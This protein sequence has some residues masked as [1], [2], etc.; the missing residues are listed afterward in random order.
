MH[1]IYTKLLHKVL[2]HHVSLFNLYVSI[3]LDEKKYC[4]DSIEAFLSLHRPENLII[5]G[6]LN[7]TLDV[8]EK[9]GGS[10][11][12][13]PSREWVE[14]TIL[15]WDLVDIKPSNGNFT[16]TNKRLGPGHIAA[17]LDRFLVHSNF[18]T[19]GLHGSS[20]ILP[21]CVSDHKPILLDLSV[22]ENLG[23]IP[24][25]FSPLWVQQDGFI[26]IVANSWS[27]K[28]TGNPSFIWE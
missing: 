10:I 7:V 11:V 24:F 13:D 9:K 21:N 2:G 12:Q 1:W 17:R 25:R 23:P 26:H 8:N 28:V 27:K 15:G 5:A 4:W 22:D 20:K 19:L 14:D 3:L 6:D 16:W 18:L